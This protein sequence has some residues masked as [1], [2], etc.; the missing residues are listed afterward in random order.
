MTINF[1][2]SATDQQNTYQVEAKAY[3]KHNPGKLFDLCNLRHYLGYPEK[4]S[5][6]CQN[7]C[8][9]P[10]QLNNRLVFIL[11]TCLIIFC[12]FGIHYLQSVSN[13]YSQLTFF[14]QIIT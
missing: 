1:F 14:C 7:K 4:N 13:K 8:N 3:E 9:T 12:F 2:R 11:R 5:N 10:N 6:A